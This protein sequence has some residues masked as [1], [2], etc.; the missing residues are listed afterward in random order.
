MSKPSIPLTPGDSL[1]LAADTIKLLAPVLKGTD[2]QKLEKLKKRA[3]FVQEVFRR[4]L[5]DE[6]IVK[7]YG[8]LNTPAVVRHKN[9]TDLEFDP[10]IRFTVDTSRQGESMLAVTILAKGGPKDKFLEGWALEF[11]TLVNP[12]ESKDVYVSLSSIEKALGDPYLWVQDR[13]LAENGEITFFKTSS[14]ELE[15]DDEFEIEFRCGKRH[16]EAPIPVKLLKAL[17]L[18]GT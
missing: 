7:D 4:M 6:P 8:D 17:S 3:P 2:K 1:S 9:E 5:D 11:E 10:T 16:I 14:G 18:K 15:Q 13:L 12:F